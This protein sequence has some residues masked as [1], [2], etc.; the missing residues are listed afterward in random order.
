M[1]MTK[2]NIAHKFTQRKKSYDHLN[3]FISAEKLKAALLRLG[4]RQGDC[5]HL[6]EP[7]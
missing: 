5:F 4:T 1:K 7:V 2:F 3:R 6:S